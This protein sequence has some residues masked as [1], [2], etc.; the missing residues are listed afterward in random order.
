M[1]R[2]ILIGDDIIGDEASFAAHQLTI[3]PPLKGNQASP[4][5]AAF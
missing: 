4:S 1:R 2:M 5:G 3:T